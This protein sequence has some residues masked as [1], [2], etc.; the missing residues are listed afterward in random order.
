MGFRIWRKGTE[1]T[2]SL[3]QH[4]IPRHSPVSLLSYRKKLLGAK[5]PELLEEGE[6]GGEGAGFQEVEEAE[7]LVHA[8]LEWSARQ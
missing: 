2:R 4:S 1:Q 5:V 3:V 8:V 7:E 6:V